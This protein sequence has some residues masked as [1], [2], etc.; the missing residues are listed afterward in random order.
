MVLDCIFCNR[1]TASRVLVH[2]FHFNE[3]HSAAIAK[4]CELAPTPIRLQ[5]ER[6]DISGIACCKKSKV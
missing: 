5:M 6:F 1:T 3:I 4:D 2:V